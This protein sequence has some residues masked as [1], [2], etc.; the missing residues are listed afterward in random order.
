VE[1]ERVEGWEAEIEAVEGGYEGDKWRAGR[2][3]DRGWR[4]G[5]EKREQNKKTHGYPMPH[6]RPTARMPS[7]RRH[8]ASA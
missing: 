1:T 6:P 5:W 2:W 8:A 4:E 7:T 3:I